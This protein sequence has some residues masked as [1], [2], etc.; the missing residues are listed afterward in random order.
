MDFKELLPKVPTVNKANPYLTASIELAVAKHMAPVT[1]LT[2][3]MQMRLKDKN[4]RAMIKAMVVEAFINHSCMI[5]IDELASQL[6]EE[7]SRADLLAIE[8]QLLLIICPGDIF[9]ETNTGLQ[10]RPEKE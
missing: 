8:V 6:E 7:N 2:Q 3:S 9:P 10:G 5:K 1:E 4:L